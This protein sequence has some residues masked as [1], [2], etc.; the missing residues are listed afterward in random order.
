MKHI[1]SVDG[2][3]NSTTKSEHR[4]E[5]ACVFMDYVSS[6]VNLKEINRPAYGCTDVLYQILESLQNQV[7]TLDNFKKLTALLL[8]MKDGIPSQK[9]NEDSQFLVPAICRKLPPNPVTE[10]RS[11][12]MQS[13]TQNTMKPT[14]GAQTFH[15]GV[16]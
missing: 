14:I 11:L 7:C 2:T 13:S 4:E 16:C 12:V 8:K 15:I 5:L 1:F 6:I 10:K 9:N 3:K